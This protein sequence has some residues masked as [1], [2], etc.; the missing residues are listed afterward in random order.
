MAA[1][2]QRAST[3]IADPRKADLAFA[4]SVSLLIF[5]GVRFSRSGKVMPAGIVSVCR[6]CSSRS[7]MHSLLIEK[8]CWRNLA[9]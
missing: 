9:V 5:F 8:R 1:G 7:R 4:V 2:V 3:G 6:D